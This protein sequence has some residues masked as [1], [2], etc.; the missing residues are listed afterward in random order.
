LLPATLQSSVKKTTLGPDF[1]S[2]SSL[3]A[4]L[5]GVI[6]ALSFFSNR[7]SR[8]AK[9]RITRKEALEAAVSSVSD[10]TSTT[11]I[12]ENE[13][14]SGNR[15]HFNISNYKVTVN[16]RGLVTEVRKVN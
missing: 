5:S 14:F 2:I 1:L 15:W 8:S 11:P 13:E 7:G 12:L 10:L 6:L 3:I 4:G 9:Q 16:N